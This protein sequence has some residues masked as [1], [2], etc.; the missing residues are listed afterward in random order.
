M[1]K[2]MMLR[3]EV[4]FNYLSTLHPRPKNDVLE[5]LLKIPKFWCLFSGCYRNPFTRNYIVCS[6]LR[7]LKGHFG[8]C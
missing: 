7:I 5:V 1:M 8:G 6:F 2:M 4:T 3:M